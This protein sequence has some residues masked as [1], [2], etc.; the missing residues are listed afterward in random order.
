MAE[1]AQAQTRAQD[2][3]L[4]RKTMRKIMDGSLEQEVALS[5]GITAADVIKAAEV[6]EHSHA[7]ED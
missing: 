6:L 1:Q 4:V 2:V 7:V 3:K 5:S